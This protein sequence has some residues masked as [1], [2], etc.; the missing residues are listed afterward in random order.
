MT[1]KKDSKRVDKILKSVTHV[2][3]KED[4]VVDDGLE[5]TEETKAEVRELEKI[6][7]EKHSNFSKISRHYKLFEYVSRADPEQVLRY[8]K[9]RGSGVEPLWMSDKNQPPSIPDCP[10]CGAPRLF[11]FQI[12]P[13]IFDRLQELLLVDWSTVCFYTCSNPGCLPGDAE[14]YIREYSYI[15]FADDFSRVQYGDDAQIRQQKRAKGEE[16]KREE[17]KQPVDA[18]K[19]DE[20]KKKKKKKKSKKD[21]EDEENAKKKEQI[22]QQ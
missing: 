11:E 14:G 17:P 6:I 13:Q 15:Q 12:M 2:D 3:D 10:L 5:D 1:G 21:A 9:Q 7:E 22:E 19:R 18:G 4:L 8:V 20:K 16:A